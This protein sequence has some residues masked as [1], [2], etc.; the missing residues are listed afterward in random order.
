MS[1]K[2]LVSIILPTYNRAQ[3]IERAVKSILS[4]TYSNFELFIIDDGSIDNTVDIISSFKDE[5][6]NCIKSKDN[7]GQVV[8]RNMGLKQIKGKYIAF[9]DSDDE[10]YKNYLKRQIDVLS[11]LDDD[12]GLVYCKC[13]RLAGNNI[14]YIPSRVIRE[15]EVKFELLGENFTTLQGVLLKGRCLDKC[16]YLDE[17]MP[18]LEDWDFFIRLSNI[19]KFRYNDEVLVTMQASIDGANDNIAHRIKSREYI[20]KKH[21]E[22]LR[23]HPDVLANHYYTLATEYAFLKDKANV[24]KYSEKVLNLK[25]KGLNSSLILFLAKLNINLC[26]LF[27]KLQIKMRNL[28]K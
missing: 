3:V 17:N 11:G 6:I 7:S 5:R 23:V 28:F 1:T 22:S 2:P 9:L 25:S 24:I 26:V 21:S 12:Y 13:R 27:I 14:S 19:C 10:W 8:A 15:E 4:Q 20:L 18:A 16:G